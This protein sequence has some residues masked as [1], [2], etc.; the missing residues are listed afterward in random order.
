MIM[1]WKRRVGG[2]CTTSR[3][4]LRPTVTFPTRMVLAMDPFRRLR[5]CRAHD[6]SQLT[7]QELRSAIEFVE[8]RACCLTEDREAL[9]QLY[10]TEASIMRRQLVERALARLFA[11]DALLTAD[12]ARTLGEIVSRGVVY[13]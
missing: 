11:H 9:H 2:F 5:R 1:V 12:Q 7:D 8:N 6:Y 13:E 10:S 3:L 4:R